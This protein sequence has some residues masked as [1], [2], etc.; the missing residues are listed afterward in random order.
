MIH[1]M[2]V[3]VTARTCLHTQGGG[4]MEHGFASGKV[5]HTGFYNDFTDDLLHLAKPHAKSNLERAVQA[6][7]SHPATAHRPAHSR[8]HSDDHVLVQITHTHPHLPPQHPFT[9]TIASS[10]R[11]HRCTAGEGRGWRRGP[12]TITCWRSSRALNCSPMRTAS[13]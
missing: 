4:L 13:P 8:P 3:S 1:V 11:A 7:V 6:L 12:W 9:L 10:T 5:I 2:T